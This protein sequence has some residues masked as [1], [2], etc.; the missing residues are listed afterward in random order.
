MGVVIVIV[1]EVGGWNGEVLFNV[2]YVCR[3]SLCEKGWMD[4]F[5]SQHINH[6]TWLFALAYLN[7]DTC[8]TKIACC[9]S[10]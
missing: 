6:K 5:A 2:V 7:W 9:C 8:F 1:M 3:S 4:S 10:E